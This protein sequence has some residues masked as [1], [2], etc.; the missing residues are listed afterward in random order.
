MRNA[1]SLSYFPSIKFNINKPI[2]PLILERE[3]KKAQKVLDSKKNVC[4]KQFLIIIASMIISLSIA[5]G[6]FISNVKSLPII[7]VLLTTICG[8]VYVASKCYS[9]Y[10]IFHEQ[11]L[12]VQEALESITGIKSSEIDR[13]THILSNKHVRLYVDRVASYGRPL[14]KEELTYLIKFYVKQTGS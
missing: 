6:I 9:N 12:P 5:V 2:D 13:Y 7:L 10:S 1:E 3:R 8:M 11:A 14:I 4:L